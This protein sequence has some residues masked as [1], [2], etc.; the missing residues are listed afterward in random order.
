MVKYSGSSNSFY[1][2][3]SEKLITSRSHLFELAQLLV[4]FVKEWMKGVNDA[5]KVFASV[6]TPGYNYSGPH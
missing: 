3:V 5:K 4:R 6:S 1:A 2:N